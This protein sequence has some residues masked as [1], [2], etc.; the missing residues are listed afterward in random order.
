MNNPTINPLLQKLYNLPIDRK[1]GLIP[2]FSLGALAIVLSAGGIIPRQNLQQQQLQQV[3][4]QLAVTNIQYNIKIDQMGFGFRGQSDNMAIIQAS[5]I[6]AKGGTVSPEL[7]KE[8]TKILQNELKARKIQ[9]ATLVGKDKRV[10][11]SANANR[12]GE[13]FN[14]NGLVSKVLK[15]PQ[16]I[17]TSEIVTWQELAREKASLPTGLKPKEGLIR[18]TATPVFDRTKKQVTGVLISGDLVDG[19]L[20]IAETTLDAFGEESGYSAVY[21]R[22]SNQD[23]VLATSMLRQESSKREFLPLSDSS[24][25]SAAAASPDKIITQ[26]S[27]IGGKPYV[28]AAKAITNQ[29]GEAV[30]VIVYGNSSDS[31]IFWQSFLVQLALTGLLLGAIALFTRL[32]G[33]VIAE[34]ILELQQIA[35]EFGE[36]NLAARATVH[37][38]DEMGVL[39]STFN[40]L[41]D[42]IATKELQLTEDAQRAS[43]LKEVA[44]R[45]GSA[46]EVDEVLQLAV[47]NG[48]IALSA[49]RV[50]YYSFDRNW[51]GKVTAESVQEGFPITLGAV[52]DDPCFAGSYAEKYQQGRYL[53]TADIR[54]ANLQDCHLQMLESFA[55]KANLVVPILLGDKLAGLLI[56]HQCDRTRDWQAQDIDLLLQIAN[57]TGNALQ[58]AEL[59]E[60]QKLAEKQ[61]REAKENLQRRAVELL[62]EVD[63]VS[64]GDL[65]VRVK[66]QEDEIGTIADSYNA[67]IENLRKLVAQVQQASMLVSTTTTDKNMSIRQLSTG[68]S[69][70]TKEITNALERI[71]EIA[72]S[73]VAVAENASAAEAAVRQAVATVKTGDEAMNRTVEGFQTIRETVAETAKKVK[74][75]GESSQKISK[76]VNLIGSFADQT[77]LLALNASIEAAHAGEEGRGFAVVADEVRSLARQSAEA[78]ADIEALVKEI[79]TETNEV[80]AAMESGTEQVVSGT[81]LVDATRQSLIQ[82]TD[83]SHQIDRLVEAIAKATVQQ[84]QDSQIVSQAMTQVAEISDKTAIEASEVAASFEELLTVAQQLQES[85]AKFKVG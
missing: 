81:K 41:A 82:I 38:T 43:F 66:V 8:I 11:V 70:Q 50:L 36:G 39:A 28:L 45:L 31:A 53:A 17:K 9:Y 57:Q 60:K 19:K 27:K 46:I 21:L 54:K 20:A 1:I 74:R 15:N 35:Q 64:R 29:A 23:F 72:K 55:V 6:A 59:L 49:D 24:I 2:W 65:T 16:Q 30:A 84:S 7:T 51:E 76:V 79:Q 62:M 10:L 25:L 67:T 47:E 48:R 77:N 42:A 71:N 61:E 13:V 58:R 32:L 12:M 44:L 18:Y 73:I 85:V 5:E 69:E 40:I 83:A 80:V 37:T 22:R 63:P 56:A 52:I 33:K 26:Q 34:P 68:A 75:L 14:P 4:S 3:K 78:T